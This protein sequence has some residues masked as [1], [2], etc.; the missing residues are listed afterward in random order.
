MRAK[1]RDYILTEDF[2]VFAKVGEK[3]VLAAPA[4]SLARLPRRHMKQLP[5]LGEKRERA[6]ST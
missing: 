6:I 2:S 4:K 3:S 5:L 1:A